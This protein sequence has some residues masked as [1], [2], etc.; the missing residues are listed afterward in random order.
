MMKPDR[1]QFLVRSGTSLGLTVAS[2]GVLSF[3]NALAVPGEPGNQEPKNVCAAKS[4]AKG[5]IYNTNLHTVIGLGDE[6]PGFLDRF[7]QLKTRNA[8]VQ[9][10]IGSP[11]RA[12]TKAG[13]SQSLQDG[14]LPIV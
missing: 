2:P 13:Y 10:E 4:P 12:V 7:G 1:R 11:P 14:Y 9:L 6:P 8:E 3:V 5:P